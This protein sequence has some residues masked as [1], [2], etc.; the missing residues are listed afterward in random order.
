MYGFMAKS[1]VWT[2][3]ICQILMRLYFFQKL[4]KEKFA[5]EITTFRVGNME[6][7]AKQSQT[8]FASEKKHRYYVRHMFSRIPNLRIHEFF[9]RN[10]LS[11]QGR[12]FVLR[13]KV[14][15]KL[16]LFTKKTLCSSF[17]RKQDIFRENVLW[18]RGLGIRENMSRAS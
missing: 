4:L 7:K 5:F 8:I 11:K 12:I 15:L 14:L 13:S 18:I 9:S 2:L 6:G 10:F 1:F 3:N 17:K 16:F